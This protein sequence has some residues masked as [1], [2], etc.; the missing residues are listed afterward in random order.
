MKQGP[1]SNNPELRVS[2][3]TV[4]KLQ[5]AFSGLGLVAFSAS[6]DSAALILPAVGS[7]LA[8]VTSVVLLL[9]PRLWSMPLAILGALFVTLSFLSTIYSSVIELR[10]IFYLVFVAQSALLLP[11]VSL[12]MNRSKDVLRALR[13]VFIA[14]SLMIIAT[15]FY[16]Q[17]SGQAVSYRFGEPMAPGVFGFYMVVAA[18]SSIGLRFSKLT[19]P[20][21]SFFA[22]LSESRAAVLIIILGYMMITGVSAKKIALA[23]VSALI[24]L[25]AVYYAIASGWEPAFLK[26]REDVS[27]GRFLIWEEIFRGIVEK[28][29]FGHGE[30]PAVFGLVENDP[31]RSFGAHNSFLDIAYEHGLVVAVMSYVIFFTLWLM[32]VTNS[33]NSASERRFINAIGV[34]LLVRSMITSTFWTNMAD[35]TSLYVFMFLCVSLARGKSTDCRYSRKYP[36]IVEKN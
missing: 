12:A 13:K 16:W 21:F 18:L 9:N 19:F 26:D 10:S 11:Q 36:V 24:A 27:S 34:A 3:P 30:S 20:F 2:F 5:L 22:L 1:V 25:G 4:L 33:Q 15:G 14:L 8:F 28:P 7:L 32:A 17:I 6:G 31:S 23:V 35:A 29:I